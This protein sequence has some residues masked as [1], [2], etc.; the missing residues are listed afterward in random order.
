MREKVTTKQTLFDYIKEQ[1]ERETKAKEIYN[2]LMSNYKG[3]TVEALYEDTI[4]N[5]VGK[6]GLALLREFRLIETCATFN[7]R[8]L[9]AV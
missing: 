7:G 1:T 5:F 2:T 6:H 9:Y 4:I 8:K 3:K